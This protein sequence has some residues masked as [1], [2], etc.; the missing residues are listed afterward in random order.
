VTAA[1]TPLRLGLIGCG[2]LAEL[3][4][5]PAVAQLEGVIVSALADPEA[6]RRARVASLIEAPTAPRIFATAAELVGS[7]AVDA[8]VIASPAAE[9]VW[10]AELAAR[11]SIP[12]LIEKPP[13]P[14]L[15]GA[16]RIAALEP[17]P[18]IG[19]N[20]RFHHGP[21]LL[22]A[23]PADGALDL[24]LE[25][26]YRRASW[27]P[28][29]PGD[30]AVLDLAPHLVD[31][32]LLLSG[33]AT[34]R[35]RSAELSPERAKIELETER[36]LASIRCATDRPHRELVEARGAGGGLLARSA[37]GGPWAA[38]AGRLPG[39]SHPLVG[40]LRDQLA[41]FAKAAAGG[42]AATLASAADG[43]R[44]MRVIEESRRVAANGGRSR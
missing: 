41:A 6:E 23:I 17:A 8:V 13:A 43:V 37:A 26:G 4:Y 12:S 30:D 5:A 14:G 2:R 11:A 10:Q 33:S 28:L 9:H 18:W 1:R 36:G 21:R 22:E 27:R 40:S 24:R 39:R 16:E 31:L 20:R 32:A 34:A 42:A 7:G 35:V 29:T 25:I 3:G 15:A 38:I 19:F 44:V